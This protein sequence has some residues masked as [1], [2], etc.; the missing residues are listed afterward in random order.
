MDLD[1]ILSGT[2]YGEW[3]EKLARQASTKGGQ[4]D[5]VY[6]GILVRRGRAVREVGDHLLLLGH[7]LAIVS[8]KSR[9]ITMLGRDDEVRARNWLDKNIS[10][11]ARQIAGTERTLWSQAGI[12]IVSDRGVDVPWTPSRVSE[13]YGVV[14]VNYSVPDDYVA[15]TGADYVVVPMQTWVEL[16]A[17]LGA[18]AIFNYLRWRRART[19]SLPMVLEQ[20]LLAEQ[21]I[22]EA[23]M[24]PALNPDLSPREG[25]WAELESAHPESLRTLNPDYRWARVV[26]AVVT[27]CHDHDPAWGVPGSPYDYL[28]VAEVLE[29][30]HPDTKIELGKRMLEKS[31]LAFEQNRKRYFAMEDGEEG[32]IVFLSDPAPREERREFLKFLVFAIH[33]QMVERDYNDRKRTVGFATEPYPSAGRS[34]DLVLVRGGFDLDPEARR[35]RDALLSELTS[36]PRPVD[37]SVLARLNDPK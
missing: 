35:K 3:T 15:V 25:A 30:L 26:D 19:I 8:V 21:L 29:R 1:Q 33:T 6:K 12:R 32:V 36:V 34:H 11:A 24:L 23:K 13:V 18:G 16:N 2:P 20:E 14:V 10:K 31:R 17:V 9:D 27:A 37:D 28:D 22:Q 4:P 7:Q 5:F